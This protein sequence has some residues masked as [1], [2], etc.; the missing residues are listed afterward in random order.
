MFCY[1]CTLSKLQILYAAQDNSCSLSTALEGQ[2]FGHLCSITL[3]E[4]VPFTLPTLPAGCTWFFFFLT[5]TML[6]LKPG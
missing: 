5:K 6:P 3:A 2:K 4:V 1:L